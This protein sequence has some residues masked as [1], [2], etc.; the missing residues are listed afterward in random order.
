MQVLSFLRPSSR[1]VPDWSF[2]PPLA[3]YSPT[4]TPSLAVNSLF[5][6]LNSAISLSY[7]SLSPYTIG[8]VLGPWCFCRS[9]KVREQ[10]LLCREGLLSSKSRGEQACSEVS[11]H[12]LISLF[13]DDISRPFC[14]IKL[15]GGSV[16]WQISLSSTLHRD[17]R[18]GLGG[19]SVPRVQH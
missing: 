12:C 9:P 6:P 10:D 14:C 2:L 18:P 17:P 13:L 4:H 7:T 1:I 15:C 11:G 19:R 3:S 5:L 8:A 16:Q